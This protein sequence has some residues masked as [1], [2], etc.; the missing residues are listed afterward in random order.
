MQRNMPRQPSEQPT[1]QASAPNFE[2][3]QAVGTNYTVDVFCRSLWSSTPYRI[4]PRVHN[5]HGTES[6]HDVIEPGPK[7]TVSEEYYVEDGM[8]IDQTTCSREGWPFPIWSKRCF[9]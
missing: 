9:I 5:S 6:S 8:M 7:L 1:T 2:V 4:A 3:L